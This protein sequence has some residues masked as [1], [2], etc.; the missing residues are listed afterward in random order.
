MERK[1]DIGAYAQALEQQRNRAQ[2]DA[3]MYCALAAM[4]D[5]KIADLEAKVKE[6]S[7]PALEAVK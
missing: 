7:K 2:N 5:Q 1:V 3:A 6:L 4:L